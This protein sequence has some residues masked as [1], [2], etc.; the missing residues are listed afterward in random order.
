MAW[1]DIT[2]TIQ[3]IIEVII[4]GGPVYLRSARAINAAA[5]QALRSAERERSERERP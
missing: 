2:S 5:P 4:Q 1:A 3:E